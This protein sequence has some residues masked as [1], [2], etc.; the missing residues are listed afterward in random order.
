MPDLVFFDDPHSF[1]AVA[2]DHLAAEPVLSTVVA[3]VTQRA[4]AGEL[5]P[6]PG[7][8]WWVVA[9]E[10]GAIVG[11]GM[12]TAPTPPYW[13]YLLPMPD[14]AAIALARAL[15]ERGEEVLAVNGALPAARI[16]AEETARLVGGTAFVDERTR[17]H[18]LGD[19]V[20]PAGVVPGRLR[21]A[22]PADV[23]LA[24]EWFAAFETDAAEQAGRPGSHGPIEPQDEPMMLARISQERLWFWEDADG[25]RVHLTGANLPSFGVARIGPVYTPKE[26]RGRGY[27]GAA[28]AGVS[29]LLLDRGDRV[30]LFTDQANPTSN[31]IYE[32]LGYRPVV[33]MVNMVIR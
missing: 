3:S 33:D 12:R 1:L 28:V 23:D 30:C 25:Q 11:S 18:A 4:A 29:R 13:L 16:V 10:R 2:G 21:L 14:E 8:R 7:P 22:T 9:R 17:L 26:E 19:L 32:K 5:P 24:L 27:A 15:H 31:R 20:E 6:S